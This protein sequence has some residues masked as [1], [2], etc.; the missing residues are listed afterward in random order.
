MGRGTME[1]EGMEGRCLLDRLKER[2]VRHLW[3]YK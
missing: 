2:K 3:E 1:G